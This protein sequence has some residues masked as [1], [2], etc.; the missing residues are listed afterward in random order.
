MKLTKY[1]HACFTVEKDGQVL[2]VDPGEFSSDFVAPEHVAVVVYTHQHS[3]HFDAQILA[4]IFAKNDD[5]LVLGPAD[6]ID[7]VEIENKR[8]VKAGETVDIGPF[9]LDFFGGAHALIHNSLPR[10]QNLG[11]LVNDLL[12]Y[13]GDSLALPEKT[14]DTLMLPVAAPWMKISEAINL[15]DTIEPRLAVPTHDAILSVSGKAIVDRMLT[16]VASKNDITYQRLTTPI[17][18]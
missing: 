16:N 8:A 1:A 12:Y 6:V 9:E 3:D 15:M 14:V 5:V 13:P 17:E 7:Q 11:V 10:P 18:L 2:V 4:D